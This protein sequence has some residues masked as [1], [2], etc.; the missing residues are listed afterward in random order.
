MRR[1][2]GYPVGEIAGAAIDQGGKPACAVVPTRFAG[3]PAA[4]GCVD[5]R[6]RSLAEPEVID[7]E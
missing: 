7:V 6:N 3:R 5:R 2:L 1:P 4:G